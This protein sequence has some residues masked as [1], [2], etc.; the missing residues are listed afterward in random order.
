MCVSVRWAHHGVVTGSYMSFRHSV[1]SASSAVSVDVTRDARRFSGGTRVG[2]EPICIS[3]D[4]GD[5]WPPPAPA[6]GTATGA[7]ASAA[8]T[9]RSP[10]APATGAG[11]LD[12]S[13][14]S[15]A[16]AFFITWSSPTWK[17]STASPS[18]HASCTSCGGTFR[19]DSAGSR[20]A[21]RSRTRVAQHW[22][23]ERTGREGEGARGSAR[24]E[25]GRRPGGRGP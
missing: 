12:R 15:S 10:P 25:T 23:R 6:P 13:P 20:D 16:A 9:P 11:V 7:V 3:P 18:R 8:A 17:G 2:L 22:A 24:A 21:R 4:G 14:L 19:R 5:P 1:Q